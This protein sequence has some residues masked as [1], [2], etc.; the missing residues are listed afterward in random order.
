MTKGKPSLKPTT[1]Q[2]V[3]LFASLFQ[4]LRTAYGT[5]DPETAKHWQV[6]RP[7]TRATIHQHLSGA[8]PYGFYPLTGDRTHVGVADFDT[9]DPQPALEFI[10]RA[11]H[12]K[13]RAYLERS[14]SKGFHAWLFLDPAGVSA[15][16]V[17][18]VIKHILREI[19]SLETEVFP[20][21]D[22]IHG[23]GSFGNFINA[24]LF[25]KS[26]SEGRTVFVHPDSTLRAFTDQWTFLHSIRKIEQ[27]TLDWII[28]INDLDVEPGDDVPND[29]SPV[30]DKQVRGYDLP[31]CVRRMLYEGVT[32]DQRVACF[33][34]AV[35][36]KRVG[37]PHDA[38]L[39]T[40][41]SWR[42]KNRPRQNRRIITPSEI[43]EQVGWAYNQDYTGYGCDEAV[44]DSFC[45]PNCPV[46][47]TR[48]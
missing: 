5:Y 31:T 35:H 24:P 11:Q 19:E 21:Q 30:V 44:V 4:G 9:G 3:T 37:L 41:M 42:L 40:L 25:G 34:I 13:I 45:D 12:Y 6:K 22:V 46:N 14:K 2:K 38:T 43:E 36:L 20:K 27:Q 8:Q 10:Q 16:K 39:V 47:R 7:V 48:R 18:L 23:N 29:R 26:V 17:R 32:F 1:D 28:G 15:R 33:R